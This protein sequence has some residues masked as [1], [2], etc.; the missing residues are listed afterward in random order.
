MIVPSNRE[1]ATARLQDEARTAPEPAAI[2][3]PAANPRPPSRASLPPLALLLACAALALFNNSSSGDAVSLLL[4]ANRAAVREM[5]A[6]STTAAAASSAASATEF[7]ASAAAADVGAGCVYLAR[8]ARSAR[9]PGTCWRAPA[10][11]PLIAVIGFMKNEAHV[12]REWLEH[13]FWQGVDAVLLLDNGS[14]EGEAWREAARGFPRAESIAAPRRHAQEAQYNE[15]AVPWLYERGIALAVVVDLDEFLFSRDER[16][17]QEV[18]LEFFFGDAEAEEGTGALFVPWV[19]F[20]S[21]G[22]RVQPPTV[23][24]HFTWRSNASIARDF[25]DNG[26]SIGRVSMLTTLGIHLQY[27][28]MGTTFVAGDRFVGEHLSPTLIRSDMQFGPTRTDLGQAGPPLQLNHYTVQS[29]E[30]F[31]SVKMRRGAADV[32]DSENVRD[33]AYFEK[34]DF[35]EVED[36][37]LRDFVA[38]ARA[39]AGT[40]HDFKCRRDDVVVSV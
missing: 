6:L 5:P 38:R 29:W 8:F 40:L 22:H 13:Y 23:R 12:L 20:G 10:G 33:R 15:L 36:T 26:K 11:A 28:G 1:I 4:L 35:R 19:D 32:A 30:F 24:E 31:E 17:L 7:F 9:A 3:A 39:N 27:L 14:S 21:S 37:A 25:L 16:S 34:Y 18:L 2:S